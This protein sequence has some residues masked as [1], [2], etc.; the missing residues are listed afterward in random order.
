MSLVDESIK[1][2]F[3]ILLWVIKILTL[4]RPA[5]IKRC[6]VIP[7]EVKSKKRYIE[8]D[9]W[10]YIEGNEVKQIMRRRIDFSKEV[11]NSLKLDIT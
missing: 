6:G 9:S 8:D 10:Y 3:T 11:I 5:D 1:P 7:I 2:C 4:D